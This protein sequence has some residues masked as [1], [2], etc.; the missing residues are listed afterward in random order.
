M[1]WV[2]SQ[3]AG[4]PDVPKTTDPGAWFGW[5]MSALV[6]FI[7]SALGYLIRVGSKSETAATNSFNQLISTLKDNQVAAEDRLNK[8]WI[9]HDKDRTAF[10]ARQDGIAKTQDEIA[11]AL[12]AIA[13]STD[14]N[15]MVTVSELQQIKDNLR[16]KGGDDGR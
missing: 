15:H 9:E 10:M 14:K 16:R 5:L 3:I 11:R 1:L 7:A 12:A 6:L 8:A 13:Q 2:L 4:M